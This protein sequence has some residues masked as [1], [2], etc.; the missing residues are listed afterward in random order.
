MD[1]IQNTLDTKKTYVPPVLLIIELKPEQVLAQACL[2][3]DISTCDTRI[4]PYCVS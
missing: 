2:T 4:V 3:P 1:T